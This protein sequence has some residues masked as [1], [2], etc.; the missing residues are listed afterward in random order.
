MGQINF[1]EEQ[2]YAIHTATNW[3]RTPYKQRAP[4]FVIAGY[5]GTGKSTILS[6]I[7][8]YM[9]IPLYKVAFATFTGKAAVVLRQRGLNA[10][11]IHKLIYNTNMS[12]NGIPIFKRK[13]R[14]PP[15]IELIA[16]DEIGMVPQSVLDDLLSFKVPTIGLGDPGQLPPIFGENTYIRNHNCML[17]KVY[18]QALESGVLRFATDIRNGIFNTNKDY[19]SDVRFISMNKLRTDDLLRCDQIICAT[20]ANKIHINV[21][22]RNALQRKTMFPEVGDKVICT[23]NNFK[24]IVACYDDLEIFLVNGLMG[25]TIF[26]SYK[27]FDNVLWLQFSIDGMGDTMAQIYCKMDKFQ[28]NYDTVGDISVAEGDEPSKK[29]FYEFFNDRSIHAM[30][31]GYAIT[32]HKSQGSQFDNVLV[33]DDCFYNNTEQYLRWMYTAV[34]R[35]S[36]TITVVTEN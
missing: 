21:A 13:A 14:L 7:L 9:H 15:S 25:K 28:G 31:Y 18:R 24:E 27:V 17:T 30:D 23:V 20:N 10:Y 29:E 5:A 12:K 4:I 19:G 34:T 3:I 1:G 11:T 33:Y 32:C 36:K 16:I 6:T 22:V 26:D 8:A 35:A 2:L